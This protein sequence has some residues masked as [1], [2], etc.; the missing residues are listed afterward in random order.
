MKT[1]KYLILIFMMINMVCS[2]YLL[3]YSVNNNNQLCFIVMT[4]S[5]SSIISLVT[6]KSLEQ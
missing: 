5:M 3:M 6:L 2:L 1:I 4:F